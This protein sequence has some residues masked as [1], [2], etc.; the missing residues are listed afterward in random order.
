MAMNKSFPIFFVTITVLF[1]EDK[2]TEF[3]CLPD[4]ICCF[5][6]FPLLLRFGNYSHRCKES[7]N[8]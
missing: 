7:K 4:T 1:I 2:V 3:Y 5:F 8:E 6:Y